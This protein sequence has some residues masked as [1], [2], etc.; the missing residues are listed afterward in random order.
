MRQCWRGRLRGPRCWNGDYHNPKPGSAKHLD[1]KG[2]RGVLLR[3]K[4]FRGKSGASLHFMQGPAKAINYG[5]SG[6]G[7]RAKSEED[8]A[9][10]PPQRG[11]KLS[12][13]LL[14]S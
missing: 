2:S 8:C 11:P 9:F 7:H 3:V 5:D 13:K 12:K 4:Q 1:L 6:T 10:A 14:E